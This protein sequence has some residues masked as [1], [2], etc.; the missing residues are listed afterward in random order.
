MA[1]QRQSITALLMTLALA[2]AS[3]ISA[4]TQLTK[5]MAAFQ[6]GV[7]TR[8]TLNYFTAGER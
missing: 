8:R 6:S 7:F 3:G 1:K 2:F 5:D 4:Q